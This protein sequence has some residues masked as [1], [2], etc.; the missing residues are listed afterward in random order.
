MQLLDQISGS[1]QRGV[2]YSAVS[3][4]L[5]I[6]I[7]GARRQTEMKTALMLSL[8]NPAISRV[9]LVRPRRQNHR[10]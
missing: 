6:S 2:P 7:S 3:Q 4:T 1:Y 9:L 10:S 5:A 8:I